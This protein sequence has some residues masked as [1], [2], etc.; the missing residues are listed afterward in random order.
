MSSCSRIYLLCLILLGWAGLGGSLFAQE[1]VG[2]GA[3][4]NAVP[5]NDCVTQAANYHGVNS[6]VLRAIIKVESNFNP[7]AINKNR[8]GTTDV[9]IA[10]INSMHFRELSKFGVGPADLMDGCVGTYVAA[11][12]LKKQ[13]NAYGNTWFAVGAYHSTTPCYN[14]RY[15]ALV[16]NSL[17]SWNVVSGRRQEVPK[18]E[19]CGGTQVASNSGRSSKAAPTPSLAIDLD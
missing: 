19:S 10:Q 13:V 9:G 17:L 14:R 11:W 1:A 8:N 15:T 2:M 5:P 18:M 6:W 4:Q 7:K 3:G 16:W 12:H